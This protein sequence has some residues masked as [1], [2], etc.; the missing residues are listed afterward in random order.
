[1][2]SWIK[3]NSATLFQGYSVRKTGKWNCNLYQVVWVFRNW[4]RGSASG[5]CSWS[6]V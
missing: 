2:N 6:L 4:L 1:M 5:C 3:G